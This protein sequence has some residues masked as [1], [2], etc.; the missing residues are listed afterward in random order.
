M[1][2]KFKFLVFTT[3]LL[4][5]ML[6]CNN[7]PKE[8]KAIPLKSNSNTLK[9]SGVFSE[10]TNKN[11]NNIGSI[12]SNMHKVKVNEIL[13]TKKYLYLNVTENKDTFWI[14]TRLMD[15]EV[16]KMYY[17]KGGLL[18]TNFESKEFK[19]TFE[20]IYLI[21]GSLV[22]ANHAMSGA[23]TM[24]SKSTSSK[25]SK[26]IISSKNINIKGSMKIAE[27]VKNAKKLEGKTIQISGV[28]TK[29]NPEIMKRNWIHLDDGSNNGFD[30]V[31]TSDIFVNEG[32][33]AT[34]KGTVTLNKDFGA[35]YKYNLIIENG[36]LI[37]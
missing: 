2:S 18:K 33:V 36:V 31:V 4:T 8:I 16:G 27:L 9:S 1:T 12:S 35:G 15:V 30:L 28:C 14:A 32:T 10:E 21:S 24:L 20:K 6:A 37:P 22:A 5:S 23:N 25:K 26:K 17:Y 13:K 3:I 29:I 34:F 19:R 7:G 11:N